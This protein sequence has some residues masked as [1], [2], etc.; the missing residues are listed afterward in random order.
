MTAKFIMFILACLLATY[1]IGC[2]PMQHPPTPI[3]KLGGY[4]LQRADCVSVEDYLKANAIALT[5]F[6]QLG[7]SIIQMAARGDIDSNFLTGKAG[8]DYLD[9]ALTILRN[10]ISLGVRPNE[11]PNTFLLRPL[12]HEIVP[13]PTK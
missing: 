12:C 1:V 11:I 3:M 10:Q 4:Q 6:Q 5:M 2:G 9:I 13:S 7:G 8:F